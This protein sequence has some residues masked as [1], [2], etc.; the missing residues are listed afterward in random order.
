MKHI[1]PLII[2][3]FISLFNLNYG[4]AQDWA[5]LKMFEEANKKIGAPSE[6][7]NRVVFMGNSITIGWLN[8]RP[9][10]FE[11]KPYINR[12]ISGQTTP[13]MLVRFRQDVIDLAPKAVVILAGTNDIAG[14]TGPS[15]IKMIMDNIK[16]M[17]EMAHANG[18]KVIL[19]STLPAYDYPW[20]PGLEPANKIIELNRMIKEYSE[21]KGHIYLDYFSKM[22][23]ERNGLP[24][25]YAKDEV[26]PTVEGYKV[27]EPLVEAAIEKA[28][29]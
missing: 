9:E 22:A 5:N 25:K 23:D 8:S 17:A 10:F 28:L 20:R 13:Q 26:H 12:G 2:A 29:K 6:G 18:I 21:A 4:V 14:N 11:G 27:M 3:L 7:E 15:T 1:K 19:S 24:K 16:G